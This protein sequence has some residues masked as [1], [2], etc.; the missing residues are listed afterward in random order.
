VTDDAL[1]LTPIELSCLRCRRTVL[2][3][4]AGLCPT[5]RDELRTI[6][7]LE[8]R[9]VAVADYEPPRHVTPNAVATRDD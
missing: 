6:F 2:M 5:C 7:D 4:F 8:G 3:R 9:D 1:D